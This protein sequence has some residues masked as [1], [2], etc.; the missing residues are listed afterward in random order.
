M[1]RRL[2]LAAALSLPLFAHAAGTATLAG[3]DDRGQPFSASVEYAGASLRAASPQTP[4]YYLLARGEKIYGVGRVNGQPIAMEAGDLMRMAGGMMPSPTAVLEQV[5]AIE[6]LQ[7][8]NR[9]ETV[10]GLDGT[11]YV[12]AYQDGRRQRRTEELVLTPDPA[13]SELTA[14]A[15]R[16]GRSLAGLSGTQLP[17][18]AD[19]LAGRLQREGLGLLRFGNRFR[20]ESLDRRAPQASRFELPGGSFQIPDLR[21]LLPGIGGSR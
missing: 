13:A 19:D 8:T 17:A 18:G 11:V 5:S 7:S 12:L 21:G 20:V 1:M 2:V 6:S 4:N 3:V 10:A 14:A 15:L 9:R 16:L